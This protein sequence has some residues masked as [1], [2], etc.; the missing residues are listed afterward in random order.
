MCLHFEKFN[1]PQFQR[2][3]LLLGCIKE[4]SYT[5]PL[6]S[7]FSSSVVHMCQIC[8]IV[9]KR[10]VT[11]DICPAERVVIFLVARQLVKPVEQLCLNSRWANILSVNEHMHRPEGNIWRWGTICCVLRK[12]KSKK[13]PFILT[14]DDKKQ[15]RA[16]AKQAITPRNPPLTVC[17][18]ALCSFSVGSK[19]K[20][21]TNTP[22][23]VA[24]QLWR[25]GGSER[26]A[27]SPKS[28]LC[29]IQSA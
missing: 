25:G 19:Y 29:W 15:Q 16:C 22:N 1:Q 12:D 2:A 28:P 3:F 27:P 20:S 26:T 6:S 9:L 24:T 10:D 11:L 5:F 23:S 8:L 21:V 14:S 18:I 13:I 17:G 7:I 4:G